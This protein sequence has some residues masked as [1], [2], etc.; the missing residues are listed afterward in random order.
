MFGKYAL[1]NK[2]PVTTQPPTTI[3]RTT[4]V[5]TTAPPSTTPL[6]I[7]TAT[8]TEE[9]PEVITLPAVVNIDD[10]NNDTNPKTYKEILLAQSSTKFRKTIQTML[11]S[12]SNI[13]L[14]S[15]TTIYFEE[16]DHNRTYTIEGRVKVDDARR[17]LSYLSDLLGYGN[18]SLNT[19]EII[20]TTMF[21]KDVA[22]TTFVG[23]EKEDFELQGFDLPAMVQ[24]FV[25]TSN[26]IIDKRYTSKWDDI[27][28]EYPGPSEVIHALDNFSKSIAHLLD[29]SQKVFANTLNIKYQIQEVDPREL[30]MSGWTFFPDAGGALMVN[31]EGCR[32]IFVDPNELDDSFKDADG[33]VLVGISYTE[34]TGQMSRYDIRGAVSESMMNDTHYNVTGTL[35]HEMISLSVI[36]TSA[37]QSVPVPVTYCLQH[38]QDDIVITTYYNTYSLQMGEFNVPSCSFWDYDINP[39]NGGAWNDAGCEILQT[40]SSYTKCFCNHTTNFAVLVQVTD[41]VFP[42]E[43][44]LVLY[45]MTLVCCGISVVSLLIAIVAYIYLGTLER[46]HRNIRINLMVSMVTAYI[47]LLINGSTSWEETIGEKEAEFACMA[48]GITMHLFFL[49]MIH[50]MFAECV[51]VF[52]SATQFFDSDVK[53]RTYYLIGW[54]IPVGIVGITAG[55]FYDKYGQNEACWLDIENGLIWS[56]TGPAAVVF[57]INVLLIIFCVRAMKMAEKMELRYK[58]QLRVDFTKA[59]VKSAIF[60]NPIIAVCWLFGYLSFISVVFAY[61]FVVLGGLQGFLTFMFYVVW[62][63]EVNNISLSQLLI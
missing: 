1:P 39:D 52:S 26:G 45:Y 63:P 51:F 29:S 12:Y 57:I 10:T 54:G 58:D 35:A 15:L 41:I 40:T 13:P 28:H 14:E 37:D 27:K 21:L 53:L 47:L 6:V 61:Q 31:D 22:T 7:T 17:T 20:R 5:T 48:I 11:N 62:N 49:A 44:N 46:M 18:M 8:T 16:Y 30:L 4:T 2:A 55:A 43:V 50:W 3:P 34:V 24:V 38:Q 33:L 23:L 59:S 9:P 36:P 60:L 32:R 25:R 19:G 56:F 42:E